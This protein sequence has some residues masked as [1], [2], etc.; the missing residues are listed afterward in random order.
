MQIIV[1]SK[2]M[3][4]VHT[5]G[6]VKSTVF[7]FTVFLAQGTGSTKAMNKEIRKWSLLQRELFSHL[8]AVG[9]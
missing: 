1:N 4:L 9:A 2:V 6:H 7:K 5:N 8:G 3:D